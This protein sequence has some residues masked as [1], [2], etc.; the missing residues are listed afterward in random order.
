MKLTK[1]LVVATGLLVVVLAGFTGAWVYG[2]THSTQAQA[3]TD[4]DHGHRAAYVQWVRS[5]TVAFSTYSDDR[6][7]ALGDYVCASYRQGMDTYAI[8]AQ[9]F[10]AF[11]GAQDVGTLIGATEFLCPEFN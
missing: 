7:L 1:G 5:R 11:G 4:G 9:L 6:L 3:A 10:V 2:L 8:G